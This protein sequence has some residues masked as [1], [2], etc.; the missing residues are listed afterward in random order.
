MAYDKMAVDSV[1]DPRASDSIPLPEQSRNFDWRECRDVDEFVR[2]ADLRLKENYWAFMKGDFK[3]SG[4][5]FTSWALHEAI[6]Y[7]K[8][9]YDWL[10]QDGT[11][12]IRYLRLTPPLSTEEEDEFVFTFADFLEE[13]P[14]LS[15]EKLTGYRKILEKRHSEKQRQQPVVPRGTIKAFHRDQK[16]GRDITKAI[17]DKIV[18]YFREFRS[19]KHLAPYTSIIEPSGIGKNFVVQQMARMGYTYVVYA[20]LANFKSGAYPHR[21]ML[22]NTISQIN[23]RGEMTMFFECY[24]AASLLH[25]EQCRKTG[26]IPKGFFEL[27]VNNKFVDFQEELATCIEEFFS[28]V[29]SE[30]IE[31]HYGKLGRH[32]RSN[33]NDDFG[34][35]DY[36]NYY[37]PNYRKKIGP[38]F[39]KIHKLLK[40]VIKD[41]AVTENKAE[42]S[43]KPEQ[44]HAILCLDEARHLFFRGPSEVSDDMRFLAFRRATRHQTRVRDLQSGLTRDN[45]RFFALLL[46]TS[47]RVSAISPLRKHDPSMKFLRPGD[48][49]APIY[50]IDS[51]DV[52][53]RGSGAKSKL[54]ATIDPVRLFSLG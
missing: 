3:D 14:L 40:E 25:I 51:K 31:R 41:R 49:F 33:D 44:P 23:E 12:G 42:L 16:E 13:Y 48:V 11:T 9:V 52:F 43:P 24:I 15:H 38:V 36:V 26:I 10:Q 30:Y 19:L 20:S 39:E 7:L 29:R 46:D 53:A 17:Y 27:Q 47:S 35:Q 45:K 37:S 5:D 54:E 8:A 2:L 21:S 28:N 50:Q 6:E 34:Y 32:V 4:H 22:A 1:T 18:S